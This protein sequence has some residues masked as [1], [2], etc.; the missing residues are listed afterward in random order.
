TRL[1]DCASAA[2]TSWNTARASRKLSAR[3]LPMPTVCGPCPGKMKAVDNAVPPDFISWRRG[4][5]C[6]QGRGDVKLAATRPRKPRHRERRTRGKAPRV[7]E[8]TPWRGL[9]PRI[10]S[11]ARRAGERET[12]PAI[13]PEAPETRRAARPDRRNRRYAAIHLAPTDQ[14]RERWSRARPGSST[15]RRK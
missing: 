8:P 2:S 4:R 5:D 15:A 9:G 3:A 11:Q 7:Y 14:A 12:A 6:H 1:S 13:W 10:R